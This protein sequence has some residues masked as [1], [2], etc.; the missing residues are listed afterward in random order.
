LPCFDTIKVYMRRPGYL[1]N[2]QSMRP[3]NGRQKLILP[4]R[5]LYSPGRANRILSPT[6]FFK[7]SQAPP[8]PANSDMKSCYDRIFYQIVQR[9][10][11]DSRNEDVV[12]VDGV[13]VE[14]P[15]VGFNEGYREGYSDKKILSFV[16]SQVRQDVWLQRKLGIGPNSIM[17]DVGCGPG[18]PGKTAVQGLGVKPENYLGIS[19]VANHVLQSRANGL[20][21]HQINFWDL[22]KI[23]RPGM[24]THIWFKGSL[25]H[26]ADIKKYKAGKSDETYRALWKVLDY[27]AAPGAIVGNSTIEFA[28]TVPTPQEL[29]GRWSVNNWRDQGLRQVRLMAQGFGGLYPERGQLRRTAKGLFHQIGEF[30]MT[31]RYRAAAQEAER[32]IARGLARKP[33]LLWHAMTAFMSSPQQ[34]T[35]LFWLL[36]F[37][38]TVS[39]EFEITPEGKLPCRAVFQIW[40]KDY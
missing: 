7:G 6:R 11:R 38:R 32:I 30:D 36:F 12:E 10:L 19:P 8:T 22:P 27:V 14:N 9:L 31:D 34:A 16:G 26:L 29:Y 4:N 23:V 15:E 28:D 37:E 17:L 1:G 40:Q 20:N 3:S 13:R 5:Q 33:W 18:G 35:A 21:A 25:E 2:V 24:F 39:R